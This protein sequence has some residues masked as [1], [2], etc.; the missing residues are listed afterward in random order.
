MLRKCYNHTLQTNP[1]YREE[2]P[3]NNHKTSGS[4]VKLPAISSPS[5]GL[6][7]TFILIADIWNYAM[8]A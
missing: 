1:R 6:N 8:H 5:S 7:Q 4:Q 3:Q 2:K